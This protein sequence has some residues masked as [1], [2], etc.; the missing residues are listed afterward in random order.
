MERRDNW[1]YDPFLR[2]LAAGTEFRLVSLDYFIGRF[3]IFFWRSDPAARRDAFD[4]RWVGALGPWPSCGPTHDCL[5]RAGLYD[6]RRLLERARRLYVQH[7]DGHQS[8][9]RPV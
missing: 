9:Q 3:A 8:N 4:R 5:G 1:I 6:D 2:P 7:G